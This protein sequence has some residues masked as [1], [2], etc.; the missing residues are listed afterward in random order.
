MKLLPPSSTPYSLSF[1]ILCWTG[2]SSNAAIASST[3]QYQD[4]NDQPVHN[5]QSLRLEEFQQLLFTEVNDEIEVMEGNLREENERRSRKDGRNLLF[6]AI[7]EGEEMTLMEKA[8]NDSAQVLF[9]HLIDH[10]W[11]LAKSMTLID[12]PK[13]QAT[14]QT[15]TN[16]RHRSR[17]LS[18]T[19]DQYDDAHEQTLN[20][21]MKFPF[22][23]CSRSPLL[24][25]GLQRLAPMLQFTGANKDNV[26]V[27]SNDEHQTCYQISTSHEEASILNK[28]ISNDEYLIFPMAGEPSLCVKPLG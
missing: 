25:S 18:I 23:V 17:Y 22:L 15:D 28:S 21:S 7:E 10:A 11:L 24:Q 8:H 14:N 5:S 6:D 19:D 16:N 2:V 9:D 26:I 3:S 13:I 1:V 4:D 20:V 27:V 12:T